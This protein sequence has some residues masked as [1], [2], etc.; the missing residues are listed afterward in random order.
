MAIGKGRI[1]ALM[2]LI[3]LHVSGCSADPG[4]ETESLIMEPYGR[5]PIVAVDASEDGKMKIS[6]AGHS[7]QPLSVSDVPQV[8]LLGEA[9]VSRNGLP[10]GQK[11]MQAKSAHAGEQA[12]I[13]LVQGEAEEL[14][15]DATAVDQWLPELRRLNGLLWPFRHYREGRWK[16]KLIPYII[17]SENAG[18][19]ARLS[20]VVMRGKE[21]VVQLTEDELRLLACL[22][23]QKGNRDRPEPSGLARES[24]SGLGKGMSCQTRWSSNGE[25]NKPVLKAQVTVLHN[26]NDGMDRA[27][28][29]AEESEMERRMED[30]L[31]RLQ[32]Q[33]VDPLDI[34]REV[35]N[36]YRGVWTV[37]RWREGW[38]KAQVQ[39]DVRH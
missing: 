27:Q 30:L 15:R 35:R 7:I 18:G 4:M 19:A 2:V 17:P 16:D 3:M 34:G 24:G 12:V 21:Q 39:V 13:A 37:E 32:E 28:T 10:V 36:R 6:E 9:F 23:G 11:G 1:M 25:L 20:S 29:S 14:L 8:V 38:R 33:Q 22:D 26:R 5:A 31:R